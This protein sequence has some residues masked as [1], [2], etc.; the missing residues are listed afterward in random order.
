M[1]DIGVDM[2]GQRSKPGFNRIH[3][4]CHAGEVATLYDL[5]DKAEFLF[6]D[7]GVI[8]PDRDGRGHIGLPDQIGAEFLQCRIGVHRLVVGVGI[9]KRR[10]LIGHHFLEDGGD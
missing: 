6:G 1:S 10:R 5:L 9:E 2:S 4:F 7:A 8:V 3:R